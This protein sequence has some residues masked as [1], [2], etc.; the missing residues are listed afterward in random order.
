MTRTPEELETFR[1]RMRETTETVNRNR[2]SRRADSAALRASREAAEPA[3]RDGAPAWNPLGYGCSGGTSATAGRKATTYVVTFPDGTTATKRSY[4]DDAPEA[5]AMI[6][7]SRDGKWRVSAIR[8]E[9]QN[10]PGQQAVKAVR[11]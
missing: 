2:R 8:A 3:F 5:V 9:A 6:Y 1:Q 10:W 4:F 11:R 7:Q